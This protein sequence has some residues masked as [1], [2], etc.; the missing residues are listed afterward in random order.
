M[1]KSFKDLKA[2]LDAAPKK[3][4]SVA[5]AQD[6][7]VLLAVKGAKEQNIADAILVGDADKIK[8]IAD[9]IGMS[10]EG[11]EIIDVK[12]PIEAA[13]EAVKQVHD[14]KADMYMKGLIDTKDFLKS[15][16]DK[17][18]GLRTGKPL[19]HV[20]VFE[21]EGY[22]RLLFLADVAFIPYPT[23]EDKVGMIIDAQTTGGMK[24]K[25]KFGIWPA[26]EWELIN[27][28]EVPLQYDCR[29]PTLVYIYADASE[30]SYTKSNGTNEFPSLKIYG[31]S[32]ERIPGPATDISDTQHLN[33]S[34]E[35]GNGKPVEVYDL[36]GRL[37]NSQS[38]A[39]Q[40]DT[41][42]LKPHSSKGLLIVRMSDGR[43]KKVIGK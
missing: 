18:V 16:L 14:G 30:V 5:V 6:S 15:V 27:R 38:S 17:E 11:Y 2:R 26:F 43:V 40:Q 7:E 37:I 1:T 8:A 42:T 33:H 28:Q 4:V 32:V 22:D 23:L 21:I 29:T 31:I 24:L 20:A 39:R 34:E 9:E 13:R 19:S 35:T 3:K 25:M 36:T 10:L 12:D 41:R